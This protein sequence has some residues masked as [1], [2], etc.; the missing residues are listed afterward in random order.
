MEKFKW[1]DMQ[2]NVVFEPLVNI[3][4]TSADFEKCL[5]DDFPEKFNILPDLQNAPY[6]MP[7]MMAR[8][9]NG[10]S[11]NI[12]AE[13][14]SLTKTM[15]NENDEVEID[16]FIEKAL[17]IDNTL[18]KINAKELFSGLILRG[19]LEMGENPVQY[20]KNNFLKI[21]STDNIF[22]IQT[23]ITLKIKEKYY[24][25]VTLGNM[26]KNEK[27]L[28]LAIELDINDRYRYNFKKNEYPY[29]DKDAIDNIKYLLEDILQNKLEDFIEKGD[30]NYGEFQ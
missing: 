12:S 23:K 28:F 15:I 21:K 25:N 5:E 9:K 8:N 22:D 27:E 13:S 10:L 11:V 30:F 3:R 26:R 17:L 20:I 7:R 6:S 19:F 29:S 4:D 24:I 1:A 14:I 2:Y 16:S 18:K